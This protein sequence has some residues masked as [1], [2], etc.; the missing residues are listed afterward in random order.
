MLD[1][2]LYF[3]KWFHDVFCFFIFFVISLWMFTTKN[4]LDRLRLIRA[5]FP[6]I[7]ISP[8]SSFKGI[9]SSGLGNSTTSGCCEKTKQAFYGSFTCKEFTHSVCDS[10]VSLNEN[11]WELLLLWEGKL[12]CLFSPTIEDLGLLSSTFRYY[13]QRQLVSV[14]SPQRNIHPLNVRSKFPLHVR[15]AVT[16][17]A[18]E[19]N[20]PH[21]AV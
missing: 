12:L 11:K 2:G 8:P 15:N 7:I 4:V 18:T 16:S 19:S 21:E 5:L 1:W 17:A 9:S 3:M 20:F 10:R 13:D 14:N 6:G